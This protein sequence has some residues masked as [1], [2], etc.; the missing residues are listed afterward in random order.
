ME[1]NKAIEELKDTIKNMDL[2]KINIHEYRKALEFQ[3]RMFDLHAEYGEF[4]LPSLLRVT[5]LIR[6][7]E[8]SA[9]SK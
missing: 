3:A 4:Y 6:K 2:N 1:N 9:S 7:M 5:N 8:E